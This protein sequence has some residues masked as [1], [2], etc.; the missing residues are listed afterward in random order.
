MNTHLAITERVF[1]SYNEII[2]S[3]SEVSMNCRPKGHRYKKHQ[4]N[5]F[6]IIFVV[7][8]V[9]SIIFVYFSSVFP[10]LSDAAESYLNIEMNKNVTDAAITYLSES[11]YENYVDITY[12]SENKVS[13][14][15]AKVNAI[16]EA[17]LYI[18]KTILSNM[19]STSVKTISLPLGCIFN[20]E[21]LY[22]RGPKLKFRVLS[23]ENFVSKVESSFIERG[24]NQTLFELF[25]LFESDI[26]ISMPLRTLKVSVSARFTLCES[27]I[28]G[29]VPEAYTDIHRSFDDLTESEID[30]LND[31]GAQL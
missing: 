16:N 18:S 3:F 23:N 17:R 8:L 7:F 5:I 9:S 1:F 10:A 2:K 22:A 29:D 27:V 19:N 24:I 21:M 30:D 6:N 15:N 25:I 26:I 28:V 12:T 20:S 4:R 11:E 13:G 14:I 31:F